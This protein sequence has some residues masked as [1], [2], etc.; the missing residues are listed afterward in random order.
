[1]LQHCAF[2]FAVAPA[3]A[4]QAGQH[5]AP[6][7]CANRVPQTE[8]R[9]NLKKPFSRRSGPITAASSDAASIFKPGVA[10]VIFVSTPIGLPR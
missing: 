6:P 1:M 5:G 7:K 3:F 10:S 4:P 2:Q 9:Q 8:Q